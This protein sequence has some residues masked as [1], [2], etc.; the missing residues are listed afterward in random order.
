MCV[1]H[2]ER[3]LVLSNLKAGVLDRF[4]AYVG[5]SQRCQMVKTDRH[6][7]TSFCIHSVDKRGSNRPRTTE[8]LT[9]V[10][11]LNLKDI[12][13]AASNRRVRLRFSVDVT[14]ELPD[15]SVGYRG[16]LLEIVPSLAPCVIRPRV[17]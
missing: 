1:G 4:G 17:C 12:L 3:M 5:Y 15:I 10:P 8:I 14:G 2:D 6:L 16:T 13:T 7:F 11:S 9:L